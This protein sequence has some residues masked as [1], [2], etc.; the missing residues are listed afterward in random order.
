MFLFLRN[1]VYHLHYF[2]ESE[3]REKRVSTRQKNK[4]AALKFLR[5]FKEVSAPK[6]KSITFQKFRAEYLSY[7]NSTLSKNYTESIKHTFEL[8]EKCIE[9]ETPLKNINT[10][11]IEK[12][13][14]DRYRISQFSSSLYYRTLKAAFNKAIEW[15]YLESNP[16]QKIKKPKTDKK[17][18]AFI[19]EYE[20]QNI[21]SLEP[22]KELKDIYLLAFHTGM[23]VSE[24]LNLTWKDVNLSER[25]IRVCNT[26]TFKTKNKRDRVIPI[27]EKLFEMLS[28]R[29]PK[30]I[31][32]NNTDYIFQKLPGVKFNPDFV[33]AR[34]KKIIKQIPEIN[35]EI[36]FHSLRHSTASNLIKNGV[37]IYLI[38]EIL[39]HESISTTQIYSHVQID[40]LRDAL[41]TLEC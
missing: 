14:V 23:R 13:L 6:N 34:F 7:V 32:L 33:S 1:G 5:E 16:M 31:T 29:F 39:G 28:N 2:S 24:I 15:N 41:K 8:F 27:N 3:Q 40:S 35:Q 38:K 22:N 18:P 19:N 17:N 20:L 21:I 30:V 4:P 26:A 9:P 36:H 10:G 11:L 12:F 25:I 37:N